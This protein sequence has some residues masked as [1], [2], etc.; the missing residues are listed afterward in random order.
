MTKK[1]IDSSS[2]SHRKVLLRFAVL[3]ILLLAA[4]GIF[5][6]RISLEKTV[7]M[8]VL[9]CG[10]IWYLMTAAVAVSLSSADRACR[11]WTVTAWLLYM[12]T[13]TGFLPSYLARGLEAPF[14]VTSPLDQQP[15]DVVVVLGG[16]GQVS[17]N[18]R[19]QG[20]SS[21]DRILLAA[22]LYHSGLTQKFI[23][24]GK[25]ISEIYPNDL[26]PGEIS[27]SLLVSLGVPKENIEVLEGRNTSEE[28]LALKKYFDQRQM[29]AGLVTSAWHLPRALSLAKRQN[30]EFVPLPADFIGGRMTGMSAT[31]LL[32]TCIPQAE[33]FLAVARMTK[34]HLGMLVGR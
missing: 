33:N 6:G 15:L 27:R 1:P 19:I 30:L 13:G 11:F 2:V 8:L 29:R 20:N 28:M 25:Q 9:P 12:I 24:T 26:S 17:V 7:T 4:V 32:H 23:C 34:E 18:P 22:Q 21:G 14:T 16:G 31:Q 5:L 3:T 10:L